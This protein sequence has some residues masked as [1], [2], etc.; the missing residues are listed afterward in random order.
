M[1][2][3]FEA[4]GNWYKGA[5]HLHSKNSDGELSVEELIHLYRMHEYDFLAVTDHNVVT[6]TSH[7]STHSLLTILGVELDLGRTQ[8]GEKYHLVALD[9]PRD[10]NFPSSDSTPQEAVNLIR[11]NGGEAIL[12][13]PYWSGLTTNDLLSVSGYLGLEIFNT[14]CLLEINRGLSLVHWDDLLTSG[15]KV[16]GFA[17]DDAHFRINDALGGWIMVKS[18]N[19]TKESIMNGIRKGH[20]YSSCGPRFSDFKFSKETVSV[21]CSDVNSIGFNCGPARGKRI[22]AQGGVPLTFGELKLTG[23]ERYIRVECKDKHGN[24]AWLNPLMLDST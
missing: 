21:G 19:L 11:S 10:F 5:L 7:F 12:A 8:N 14:S 22:K 3:P 15:R 20:F 9:I 13:H 2:N 16:F 18:P 23:K 1:G 4:E 24:S 17:V 6:N